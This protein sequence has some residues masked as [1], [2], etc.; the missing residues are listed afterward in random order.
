MFQSMGWG[1]K[2]ISDGLGGG[3]LGFRYWTFAEL[4]NGIMREHDVGWLIGWL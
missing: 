3:L 1:E 2:A 4:G